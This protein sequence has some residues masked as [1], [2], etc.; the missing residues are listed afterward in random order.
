MIFLKC[1]EVKEKT[2]FECKKFVYI[3]GFLSQVFLTIFHLY[4]K[5]S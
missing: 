2:F 3:K 5:V 1:Q 4:Q